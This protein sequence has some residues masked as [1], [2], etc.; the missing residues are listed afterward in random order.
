MSEPH[1]SALWMFRAKRSNPSVHECREYAVE[2]YWEAEDTENA[3]CEARFGDGSTEL[4][5]RQRAAS[6][7]KHVWQQEFKV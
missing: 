5:S 2:R 6:K 3:P 1:P 4:R 7:K